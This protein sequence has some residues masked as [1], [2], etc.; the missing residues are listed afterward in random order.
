M[1]VTAIFFQQFRSSLT[2]L[3]LLPVITGC[4]LKDQI[5]Q[6]IPKPKTEL[7]MQV[8]SLSPGT[9]LISGKTNLPDQTNLTVQAVR[10]LQVDRV[11]S[12]VLN[13]QPIDSVLAHTQVSVKTG[14]WETELRLHHRSPA[15]QVVEAWQAERSQVDLIPSSQVKFVVMTEPKNRAIE[16]QPGAA[17]ISFASNGKSFVRLEESVAISPPKQGT[18]AKKPE[19]V[20]P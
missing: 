6:L 2:V 1:K 17:Q 9:Y 5:D 11:T 3:L 13:Q 14:V 19:V 7:T 16:L 15:G 12:R 20:E 18:V 10:S 8:R 4:E